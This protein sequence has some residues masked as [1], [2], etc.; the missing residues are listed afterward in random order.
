MS[1]ADAIIGVLDHGAYAVMVTVT[2][3]RKLLDRRIHQALG[4]RTPGEVY[5]Q[6]AS[7]EPARNDEI[8]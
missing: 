8:N 1:M 3:D 6:P 5:R 4:Y 7:S 2:R